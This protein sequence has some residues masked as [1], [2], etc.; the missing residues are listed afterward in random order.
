MRIDSS[1]RCML[2]D[3]LPL[4]AKKFDQIL[5]ST[6]IV[7]GVLVDVVKEANNCSLFGN[8]R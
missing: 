2:D 1:G 8:W 4:L 5:L 6:D 3:G 7:I